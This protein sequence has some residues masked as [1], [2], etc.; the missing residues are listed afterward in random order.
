MTHT[1]LHYAHPGLQPTTPVLGIIHHERERERPQ[2]THRENSIRHPRP[3]Q[4]KHPLMLSYETLS[5]LEK[6]LNTIRQELPP[7]CRP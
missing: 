4:R 3:T 2:Q 6:A 5:R 7:A 1:T